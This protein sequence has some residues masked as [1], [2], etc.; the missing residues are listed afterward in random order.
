MALTSV[1]EVPLSNRPDRVIMLMPGIDGTEANKI[2]WSA[3]LIARSHAPK[4]SGESAARMQPISGPG[5]FGIYFPDPYIWYQDHGIQPF[6]MKNLA[7]KTIPMWIDDPT[8]IERQKNPKAKVRT[9]QSGRVQVLIF[10][11]AAMQGQTKSALRRDKKTG[12][13]VTKQVPRSFPGA[14]GRIGRR[15]AK[16]PMT[17]P[18]R[19][20][21]AV[22]RGNVG[23][24]WR[25]PGLGPRMFLNNGLTM[26]AQRYGLLPIRV[27]VCDAA[28]HP[29]RFQ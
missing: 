23:V 27:Y 26:A 7:G 17:T 12:K 19:V 15:E 1:A 20:A 4:L 8:G 11:K 24:R 9:T 25:H 16:M 5:W 14:P 22:A 10:R 3:T 2:A 29:Q 18:G 6:T 13:M 28:S 21:G